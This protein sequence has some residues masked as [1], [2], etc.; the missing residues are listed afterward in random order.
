MMHF[1]Q[2]AATPP[3]PHIFDA[4]VISRRLDVA[5]HQLDRTAAALSA[6]AVR[7]CSFDV[8]DGW[9]LV[10]EGTFEPAGY[11]GAWTASGRL[12]ARAGRLKRPIAVEVEISRWSKRSAQ[13]TISSTRDPLRWGRR[14]RDRFFTLGHRAANLLVREAQTVSVL[15][16]AGDIR[17]ASLGSQPWAVRPT[18]Q[19]AFALSA[20]E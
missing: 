12:R 3:P 7:R 10:L 19:P 18:R 5:G 20:A 4:R 2:G 16:P 13:L 15:H 9:E 14:R 6:A 1:V 8:G 11:G 17:P